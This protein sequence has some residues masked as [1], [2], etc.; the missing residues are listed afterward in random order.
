MRISRKIQGLPGWA[1]LLTR[2]SCASARAGAGRTA[3]REIPA[4]AQLQL[5][6]AGFLFGRAWALNRRPRRFSGGMGLPRALAM[7]RKLWGCHGHARYLNEVGGLIYDG[8]HVLAATS[9]RLP[10]PLPEGTRRGRGREERVRERSHPSIPSSRCSS[11]CP[12]RTRKP[13]PTGKL[14]VAAAGQTPSFR[15]C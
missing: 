1:T 15:P 8:V 12:P 4:S 6:D 9:P 3:G 10:P 11:V 2:R 14:L 13:R 7:E 5:G